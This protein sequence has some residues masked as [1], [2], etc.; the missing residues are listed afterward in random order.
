MSAAA[1]SCCL[2]LLAEL[3]DSPCWA[4]L[5]LLHLTSMGWDAVCFP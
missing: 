2:L 4:E 3:M 5:K 1:A